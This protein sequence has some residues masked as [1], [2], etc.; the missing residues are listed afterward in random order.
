[1]NQKHAETLKHMG[2]QLPA[3]ITPLGAYKTATR[4]GDL[5]FVSG[6]GPFKDG[7]P[8]VGLV[9]ADL[10]IAQAQEAAR[11]TMIQILACVDEACGLENVE[12]CLRL[13]VYVR[14]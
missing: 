7:E 14:A 13:T 9:G 10:S 1:M 5:L 8:V 2:V 6:L 12:Q 3:P 4:S 11:L